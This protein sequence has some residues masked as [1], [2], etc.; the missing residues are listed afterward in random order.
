MEDSGLHIEQDER[1]AHA[2]AR[3]TDHELARLRSR[4]G[5]EV[6]VQEAPYLTEVTRDNVR[7]WAWA[8]GD[9]N[10]LY[11]DEAYARASHYGGIIAP[12]TMLYAFSR[13]SIGYRGGLPGIHSMFGGSSWRWNRRL[14]LG[15]QIHAV[16]T[17]KG[18]DEL[19]SRFAGRMFKQISLV[20]F[21]TPDDE[22]VAEVEAWG[23]RTERGTAKGKGKYEYLKP[24]K[25]TP[26]DLKAIAAEYAT[27]T[28]RGA[29]PL[30]WDD[31]EIGD[32]VPSIVRGPY[33]ATIAVAFE[34]AW[35]GLFIR[36]HGFW[37]DL[38]TR[39]PALG[40][41]NEHGVPEPPEAVHWDAALARSAGVPTAY[42]Y[43]PERISWMATMLTNWCGD[44]GQLASLHCEIRRF[45]L[46]GDLTRC[47]GRVVSKSV[48]G[49]GPS[50]IELEL[51]AD[52]QRGERTVL[53]RAQVILPRRD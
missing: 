20:R 40:L 29:E 39:H 12:P 48:D 2:E 18:L 45:N 44:Q 25:Y 46:I 49:T 50:P 24:Q 15:E 16:V 14:R 9:R 22:Q 11:L 1:P 26:D 51:W 13:L 4:I 35:G 36:A 7:H 53:G 23:M 30:Y 43:G 47:H 33:T 28:C 17:F 31:V 34:Q 19:P 38:I 52:D 21:L 8:T 5:D 6:S 32:A 3:I 27:E 10:P 42:D 41:L 37:F